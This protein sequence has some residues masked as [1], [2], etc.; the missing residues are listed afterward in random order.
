MRPIDAALLKE[1]A[2]GGRAALLDALAPELA[3]Q[4][5]AAGLDAPL[6]QAHFLAQ[7]C[8]ETWFFSR[9]EED[10]DYP[11]ARLVTVWKHLRGR[12][13][14]LAHNPEL[15]ANAAYAGRDGNGDEASGDGW[16][17]RGRGCLD[18]TGRANYAACGFLGDP[19]SAASAAGAVASAIAFW[20]DRE[21]N[22]PADD[23]DIGR[24]TELVSGNRS[25]VTQRAIIKL[26]ALRLLTSTN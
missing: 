3:R 17:Y 21:I 23:D 1:I 11:A 7:A 2:Q 20:R 24:V 15:L 22:P 18:I 26:R 19:D 14:E 6:R 10:L 16:R 13:E 9:L 4:L 12:G 5:A 25:S 8:Y